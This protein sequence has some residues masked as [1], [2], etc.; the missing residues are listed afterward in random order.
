[1]RFVES[2]EQRSAHYSEESGSERLLGAFLNARAE[3]ATL[4][5]ELEITQEHLRAIRS[6]RSWKVLTALGRVKAG[7][8]GVLGRLRASIL[9]RNPAEQAAPSER[10]MR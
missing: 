2:E 5:E 4:A 8:G 6:S 9:R 3:V 7:V 1:M 10:P